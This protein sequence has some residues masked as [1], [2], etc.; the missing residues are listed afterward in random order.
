MVCYKCK[1]FMTTSIDKEL[2]CP[3]KCQIIIWCVSP[4]IIFLPLVGWLIIMLIL[5]DINQYTFKH[6]CSQCDEYLGERAVRMVASSGSYRSHSG[7]RGRSSFGV[8][9]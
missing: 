7:Y 3:A 4:F 5:R 9:S 2:S 6:Y 1:K 8:N